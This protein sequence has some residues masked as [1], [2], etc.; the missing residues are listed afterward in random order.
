MTVA[1][2][3]YT[4]SA[5]M[6]ADYAARRAKFFT[7]RPVPKPVAPQPPAE[8]EPIAKP[9]YIRDWLILASPEAIKPASSR[10]IIAMVSDAFGISH[11]DIVGDRRLAI[12]VRA[13]QICFYL[14][15]ECSGLSYPEIARRVGN[16]DHTTAMH[17]A[18]KIAK[19]IETDEKLRAVVETMT[20][21]L[22]EGR[23]PKKGELIDRAK[24]RMERER[25]R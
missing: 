22:Q 17:G 13:R 20:L 14:M 16:R 2:I 18:N 5:Q 10:R 3:N 21:R 6:L 4:D 12:M 7:P 9:D 1:V 23:P 8:P 15:R 11:F 24:A 25:G 19:L